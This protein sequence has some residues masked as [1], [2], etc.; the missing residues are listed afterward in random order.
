MKRRGQ[1]FVCPTCGKSFYRSPSQIH[2]GAMYCC[3]LC[4]LPDLSERDKEQNR[5]GLTPETR[6]KIRK[7]RMQNATTSGYR[8]YHGRHEHRVVAEAI[9]G[10]PLLPGEVVH[11]IDGN[12]SNNQP[13]NLMIFRSQAEHAK[14]HAEHVKGGDDQ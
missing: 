8:K 9:L 3:R 1:T 12:K 4:Y 2:E 10:R 11:H 6:E 13:E 14:Y 5:K 7:K